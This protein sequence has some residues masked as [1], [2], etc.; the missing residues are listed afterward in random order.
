[1][2]VNLVST[3]LLHMYFKAFII[4]LHMN[5]VLC[6]LCENCLALWGLRWV[7]NLVRARNEVQ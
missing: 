3:S 6:Y 7:T 1:M 5:D 2:I 4:L